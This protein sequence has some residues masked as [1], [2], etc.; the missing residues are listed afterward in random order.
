MARTRSLFMRMLSGQLNK[1][2]VF[3]K[4]GDL[5]I[6]SKY[7]DMSKQK[8]TTKQKLVQRN[9][10]IANEKSRH[11]MGDEILRAEAQVRLNVTTN[12]LYTALIKEYFANVKSGKEKPDEDEP[13]SYK[14]RKARKKK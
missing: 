3:K 4:Y 2:I 12:K 1:E 7:P 5:T 14:E 6:V 8:F 9:M 11:I 10:R 13:L